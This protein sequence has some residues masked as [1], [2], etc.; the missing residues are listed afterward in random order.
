[1][2]R[3]YDT[4]NEAIG[5]TYGRLTVL[6][7]AQPRYRHGRKIVL[8][9]CLCLCGTEKV[10]MLVEIQRGR[11]KS[12]RCL[13]TELVRAR[14]TIHGNCTDDKS[15]GEYNSWKA[16]QRRCNDASTRSFHRYGG[17]GISVCAEWVGDFP[18]FLAHVGPKPTPKHSLDR[19]PNPDG[20]YEPGNVRWAT[21]S[22]QRANL[23]TR[24]PC[25]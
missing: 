25:S 7:E 12:C 9:E 23:G 18:A 3:K 11:T 24:S 10:F 22:E 5:R 17:R 19:Y 21:R 13:S 16:M 14:A 4:V 1:M 15:S 20:N 8:V 6:R 2:K